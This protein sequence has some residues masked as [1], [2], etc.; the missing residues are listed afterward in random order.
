MTQIIHQFLQEFQKD[1]T[2]LVHNLKNHKYWKLTLATKTCKEI[3][4]QK[5]EIAVIAVKNQIIL[6]MSFQIN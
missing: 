6:K 3:A 5:A 2:D 4:W 1:Q